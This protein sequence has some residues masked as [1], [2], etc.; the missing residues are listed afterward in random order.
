M[1]LAVELIES[2]RMSRAYFGLPENKFLFLFFFDFRS[3]ISRKNP[4][5]VIHAFL[6]AFNKEY[7][8][9][10]LVIK[11]NG[12]DSYPEDYNKFLS[13]EIVKDPRIILIDKVLDD[14]EIKELV[15]LCDCFVSLH[16]SEGFG[17]GLAEAMFFGKPVIATGYSGNLDFMNEMNSCLVDHVLV[18]VKENEY[19]YGSGQIWADPDI[20]QAAWYMKRVVN[21]PTYAA[22]I[23]RYAEKYIKTYHSFSAIGTRYKRRLEKLKL[24]IA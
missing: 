12:T 2:V 22:E 23:G 5:A 11:M 17:R 4:L 7:N 13:S 9:V 14:R 1:P 19:P 6:L 8:N 21:N 20:E 24:L 3:Y 18:S 10:Y 16:R 15:R